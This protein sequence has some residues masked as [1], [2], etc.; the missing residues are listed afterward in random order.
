M[1]VSVFGISCCR[2]RLGRLKEKVLVFLLQLLI[3]MKK[4]PY[5]FAESVK[6]PLPSCGFERFDSAVV[7]NPF[8]HNCSAFPGSCSAAHRYLCSSVI[9]SRVPGGALASYVVFSS[10]VLGHFCA[11]EK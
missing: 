8:L 1:L 11:S 6:T 7:I 3:K 5:F 4:M 9:F 10:L 2:V